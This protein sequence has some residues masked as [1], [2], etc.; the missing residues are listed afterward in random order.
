VG[1]NIITMVKTGF[2][3]PGQGAQSVGMGKEVCD[4]HESARTIFEQADAV[5]G[6][7]ISDVCFNGPEEELT[8][9]KYSQPAILV[10][11]LAILAALREKYPTLQPVVSLGLSLGE[12]T[13]LVANGAM[14]FEDGLTLVQAR[15]H[16][17][18]KAAAENAGTMASIIG[19]DYAVCKPVCDEIEGA[20]IANL[21]SSQQIVISGTQEGVAKAMQALQDKGAKRVIQLQ[22]SGA[23]H[24]PLMVSA[25]DALKEAVMQTSMKE[26]QGLFIPNVTAEPNKNPEQIKEDLL[27]QLTGT[28]RW[29]ESFKKATTCDVDLFLEIGPGAVLK[30]LAR[31]IDKSVAVTSIQTNEDIANIEL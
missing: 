10:T 25:Q 12:Y 15:A 7:S 22:V 23:F 16:A 14:S 8:K 27:A 1:G 2:L 26:P 24:S 18:E 31:R 30:G 9:T 28:V 19:S 20:W 11:S 29:E 5:L 3:F 6:Y 17:M 21:N 4:Q 13:A